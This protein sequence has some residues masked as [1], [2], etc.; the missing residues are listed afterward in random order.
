M[1]KVPLANAFVDSDHSGADSF[2]APLGLVMCDHC[3]LIQIREMVDRE[4]LFS[5]Y[6]WVTGT[7]RAAAQHAPWLASRLATRHLDGSNNF[8]V[9]IASND[10]FFLRHYR[11]AGFRILGVDPS[12][13]ALT[14]NDAGLPSIRGFFG[15]EIAER[16]VQEH[17]QPAIVVAR[18]V[19]GHS[20][21][22][23]DLVKGVK[24]MLAPGGRLVIE[25]PYGYLMREELQYDQIFHEHVSYPTIQSLS[26]LLEQF[27][28]KIVDVGFVNMNGGSILVEAAH[29]DDGAQEAGIE[30]KAFENF[31]RLNEPEGWE[32][33]RT[34]VLEQRSALVAMLEK[35]R[36]ENAVVTGYGA[37]A[38][39]MTMLNF[40][41]IDTR[42]ISAFGDAN[43]MKQGML[44]P[45]VRIPVV[46]PEELLAMNP[47][48]ILLGAWNLKEEII[49]QF[50]DEWGYAGKFINPAPMPTV[51]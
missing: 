8:L 47:D 9:E 1:G 44:C 10:G 37:A 7:S 39:C 6:L 42:L 46:S 24:L 26:N 27:S 17:G 51:I 23:R 49:R 45:G 25:H 22:L 13:I 33:F 29:S 31:I 2:R 16:I 4:Q 35:L 28:L 48:Y 41:Q 5:D 43:T 30:M 15:C 18:N 40:C 20:S 14:A 19:L 36:A 11:D 3:R 12:N 38:K 50:R 32:R 21:E 34:A